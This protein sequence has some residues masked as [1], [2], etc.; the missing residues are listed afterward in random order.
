M[1]MTRTHR[2]A[3]AA[4]AVGLTLATVLSACGS[5]STTDTGGTPNVA[6]NDIASTPRDQVA[7]GGTVRWPIDEIPSNFNY[8]EL[9]GTYSSTSDIMLGMLP[10]TYNFDAAANASVNK[11]Y[12][13]SID[14]TS[15]SPQTVTYTIN[16][17]AKWSDGKPITVADMQAQWKALNG[18]DAKFL[19]S[20]ST[21]YENIGSVTQG[22]DDHQAVVVFKKPF[23]DWKSLYQP[24]YPASINATPDAF[25]KSQVNGITIT[26]GPF[27]WG[28]L[29]KTTQSVTALRDDSWWGDK[30]KLDK[31]VYRVITPDAQVDALANKEIDFIDVGPDV[32]KLQRA[33]NTSGVVVR[34]AAGPNFRH[35]T[36]NGTGPILKDLAVRTAVAKGIDRQQIANAMLTPLGVTPTTLGNHIFMTNQTGYQDNSAPVAFNP[37]AAKTALDAAGWKQS[38]AYRAKNGQQLTLNLLIPTGVATATQESALIQKQLKDIGVEVKLTSRDQD[39]FDYITAGKFDLTIFSW[40]GTQFPISSSKSIYANPE[41]DNI[42]QN[43]ARIGSAEIDAGFDKATAELDA[44]KAIAIANDTD[45]LI[46]QEV[47][48][49]TTYQRPDIKACVSSLVNYGA[50]GFATANY[51]N[52]GFVKAATPAAS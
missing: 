14:L 7:D 18:T 24:L 44:T 41:G 31:I 16:P 8:N 42:Q 45:K 10:T 25:N 50:L 37:E 13:T 29:D 27:K 32:N 52:I 28:G 12:F 47:H 34:R 51:A 38:G 48:S 23:A 5:S 17:S 43:F 22:T 36:F 15:Q 2:R 21:G 4:V 30:A 1:T 19:I 39:F 11:D 26:A 3:S 35:I 40:L 9:D 49:M 6:T 46:W 33:T 20:S